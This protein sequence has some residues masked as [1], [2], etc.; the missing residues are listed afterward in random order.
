MK[1]KMVFLGGPGGI[2]GSLGYLE[3]FGANEPGFLRN[4]VIF[5]DIWSAWSSLR[6]NCKYFLETK[7]PTVSFPNAQGP[8]CRLQQSLGA[9][10]KFAKI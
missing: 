6:L 3:S 2:C 4:L 9:S 7:V 8:R 5:G 10:H 1:G